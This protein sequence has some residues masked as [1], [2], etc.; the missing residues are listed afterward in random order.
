MNKLIALTLTVAFSSIVSANETIPADVSVNEAAPVEFQSLDTNLD[1]VITLA[2]IQN[3][4]TLKLAFTD[5]D[6]DKNGELTEYEYN[7]FSEVVK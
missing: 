1:G 2:E 6:L 7:K 4:D 3:E 5:L